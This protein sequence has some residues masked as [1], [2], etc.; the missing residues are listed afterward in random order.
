MYLQIEKERSPVTNGVVTSDDTDCV[1]KSCDWLSP[2][3]AGARRLGQSERRVREITS[4][5]AVGRRRGAPAKY[6]NHR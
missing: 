2:P 6:S 3:T 4:S 5:A 1:A